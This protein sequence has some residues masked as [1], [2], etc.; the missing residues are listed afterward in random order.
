MSKIPFELKKEI[1]SSD[2]RIRESAARELCNYHNPE[3]L[4]YL[5]EMLSDDNSEVVYAATRSII[6]IGSREAIEEII[7]LLSSEDARLRNLIVE[8]ISKIGAVAIE[9]V[10]RLLNDRDKDIRKFAVDILQMMETPEAEESLIRALFDDNVNVVMAASDALGSVGTQKA[11]PY[12]IQCLQQE[13]WLECAALKS[14]GK[15]GG[16]EALQAILATSPEGESIVLFFAVNALE[17]MGDIRG[18]DFLINLLE[19]RNSSLEPPIIQAIASILKNSDV[20]TI[21]RVK[22]KLPAQKIIALLKKDNTIVLKSTIALLGIF[23]VEEAVEVLVPLYNESNEHLFEELEDALLNIK[24]NRVE[25]IIEI[26]KNQMEPE[27][28]KIAAVKLVGRLGKKE[29]YHPLIALLAT[30]QGELKKEITLALAALEDKRALTA[31]HSLLAEETAEIKEA[32]VDA[33][34]TFRDKSSIPHLIRLALDPS[35]SVRLKAAKSLRGYEQQENKEDI[36]N[37]LR[38]TEPK[39]NSFG[40]DM[41]PEQLVTEFEEDIFILCQNES[42]AVRKIAVERISALKHDRAFE[43]VV[44][45]LKDDMPQVR[46]AG[47]RGLENYPDRDVGTLLLNAA[48]TDPEEWNRYEAVSVIGRLRHSDMLPKIVSLLENATDIVKAGVLDVLG[49][50]GDDEHRKNIEIYTESDN[51]LLKDAAMDALEKFGG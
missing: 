28:V 15:I 4:G 39:M 48:C 9:Q 50:C 35:A 31:F 34:E 51:Q 11:V 20:S 7:P 44:N 12:L 1:T 13:P 14:L 21:E 46:L 29:S 22:R 10:T 30:C 37:L 47:I 6:S 40:L 26:I 38:E 42:D 25:P 17:S 43:T 49:E 36:V 2:P 3:S 8:I 33:L 19:N 41:I 32:A 23:H 45:S 5:K 27:T 24:S 18:I 16:E